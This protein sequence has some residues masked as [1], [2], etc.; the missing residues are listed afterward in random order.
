VPARAVSA[1]EALLIT[2]AQARLLLK[3]SGVTTPPVPSAVITNLPAVRAIAERNMPCSGSAHWTGQHWLI[4]LAADEPLVR[5]RFSLFHEAKHV[6]D[7]PVSRHLYP[8]NRRSSQQLSETL[9]DH[10]AGCVLMPKAWLTALY[11]SGETDLAQLASIFYVSERAIEVRL[12]YLG[13]RDI[14]VTCTRP[15]LLATDFSSVLPSFRNGVAA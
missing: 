13:L 9:A 11:C 10:F 4:A 3:R 7:H 1:R 5:Q 2:E 15:L 12:H 6:I 8:S 14:D